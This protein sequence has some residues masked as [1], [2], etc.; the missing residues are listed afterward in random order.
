MIEVVESKAK[1]LW[2][3]ASGKL[4]GQDYE[5]VLIPRLE[6]A[7][8]DHGKVRLL[9]HL[10]QDFQGWELGAMWD[11]AK[12]GLQHRRDFDKIAVVGGPRWV[13]AVVK[14]FVPL[15][16][17]EVRT[18]LPEQLAEAWEWIQEQPCLKTP[19]HRP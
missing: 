6:E 15:M 18:M 10:D 11:D 1:V 5:E 4:T 14:I 16:E 2:L 7:I 3:R 19:P 12:F 8:R 17:G 13:D 9:F